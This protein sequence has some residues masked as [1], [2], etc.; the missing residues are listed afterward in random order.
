MKWLRYWFAQTYLSPND[1]MLHF[2]MSPSAF[3]SLPGWK[4]QKL[5]KEL[6]IL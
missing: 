2:K 6:G 3:Y 5:K 1:F 4:Q